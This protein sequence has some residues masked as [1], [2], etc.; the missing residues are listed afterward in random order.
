MIFLAVPIFCQEVNRQVY[1]KVQKRLQQPGAFYSFPKEMVR[2]VNEITVRLQKIPAGEFRERALKTQASE[3]R[4][5][6]GHYEWY[7]QK[8][9]KIRWQRWDDSTMD[10]YYLYEEFDY[11]VI[12]CEL[13]NFGTKYFYGHELNGNQFYHKNDWEDATWWKIDSNGHTI[14]RKEVNGLEHWYFYD[15]DGEL[16]YSKD[17][18]G[19]EYF[20]KIYEGSNDFFG[21]NSWTH[22]EKC[23]SGSDNIQNTTT[24]TLF[25]NGYYYVYDM[26]RSDVEP[27]VSIGERESVLPQ[28]NPA[29]INFIQKK[30]SERIVLLV[31]GA[32]VYESRYFFTKSGNE[33]TLHIDGD[34]GGEISDY[35]CTIT[36]SRITISYKIVIRTY[37]WVTDQVKSVRTY[38]CTE[39]FSNMPRFYLSE[40][41]VK[42]IYDM[43]K[44]DAGFERL[45]KEIV[46]VLGKNEL[47]IVR[48]LIYAKH[49]YIFK[50]TDLKNLFS[51]F[52]WYVPRVSSSDNISLS[53]QEKEIVELI[54][55]YEAEK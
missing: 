15:D 19:E 46:P 36:K 1:E 29:Y 45:K 24:R 27:T 50:S 23:I 12:K 10:F 8:G 42:Y 2:Q 11:G 30:P 6:D 28:Y 17:S 3:G 16:L 47:R 5:K 20:R 40:L 32:G 21:F 54:Q 55:R 48:N 34:D 43:T 22:Y 26:N 52:V 25:D 35:K 31:E 9:R 14:Y 7:D 33:I 38:K 13:S 49:G 53:A 18:N 39:T 51:N 41:I 4:D 44:S 37:D